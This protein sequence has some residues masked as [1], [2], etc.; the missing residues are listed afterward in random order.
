MSTRYWSDE[1]YSQF[2]ERSAAEKDLVNTRARG[3]A[4]AG[5][6]SAV[7]KD[8]A[9][10]RARGNAGAG[11]TSGLS[12]EQLNKF[13]EAFAEWSSL[14]QGGLRPTDFRPFLLQLGLD[15]SRAQ[16]A[17]LWRDY[18]EEE[19]AQYLGYGGA[20]DA[21]LQV[22][23][24]SMRFECQEETRPTPAAA[25]PGTSAAAAA[26]SSL[27]SEGRPAIAAATAAIDLRAGSAAQISQNDGAIQG[28][29]ML[30]SAAR[31]FLLAE[32]LPA[33]SVES[34]LRPFMRHGAVPQSALFDFLADQSG[35]QDEFFPL[36]PSGQLSAACL[37]VA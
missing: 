6:R 1:A 19:G 9:N 7:E 4:G 8:L 33:S 21:Y 22:T 29:G 12:K 3:N 34:F 32:G 30:V 17:S 35:A 23:C 5:K 37:T 10:S 20:L 13:Q 2:Y 26:T 14:R 24:G 28:L 36:S 15:L 11:S 25:A 16:T 27:G 31:E 18:V